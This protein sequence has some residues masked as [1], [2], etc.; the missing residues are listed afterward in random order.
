MSRG[1]LILALAGCLGLAAAGQQAPGRVLGIV[2]DASGQP[3]AGAMVRLS[4][5]G[6]H[7]QPVLRRTA[8]NGAFAYPRLSA[9]AYYIE[10]GRGQRVS[11]RHKIEVAPA[12]TA[13][14][15]LPL[16][17]VLSS[18]RV[19]AP[20]A[21]T[22]EDFGWLLRANDAVR[23]ILRWQETDPDAERISGFISVM[24]GG[25]AL[26]QADP[27]TVATAFEVQRS[28]W[29]DSAFTFGG[30]VG[31]A[32]LGVGGTPSQFSV[33]F[34]PH[35]DRSPARLVVSIQQ[36]PLP[37]VAR[38]PD[39]QA[40]S[41]NYADEMSVGHLTVQYGAMLDT[42]SMMDSMHALEP[43]LRVQ[44]QAGPHAHWE[45][46]FASAVPPV[47]FGPTYAQ[48]DA[49]LRLALDGFVASMERARHQEIGYDDDLTP[50]DRVEIAAFA[51]H[52]A[53]A[54]VAGNGAQAADLA[55]GNL[56][57]DSFNDTFSAD[58][59][60]YG[61][62][63]ARLE[64]QRRLTDTLR[65]TVAWA[66]SPILAPRPG[67]L[68]DGHFA[69]LLAEQRR[70]A[71]TFKVAGVVPVTHTR[72]AC[73]YRWL[74]GVSATPVDPYDDSSDQSD[75]FAN[76]TLRQ[77]LPHFAFG[78]NRVEALA[79]FHNLLAQGYIPVMSADGHLLYLIQA[80]R[81]FRGGLSFNF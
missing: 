80:A 54:V 78:G 50:N 4:P 37:P 45:Y 14:L 26:P 73:S 55:T 49:A 68:R 25:S 66:N 64:Y 43:Y 34:Q 58:G 65:A 5:V 59:G 81:S 1:F 56:L 39:V 31:S 15:A 23:P 3:M 33:A 62:L 48:A 35:G 7:R 17:Y 61:G 28:A 70:Q 60:N 21:R 63:G 75:S 47:H 76:I 18:L 24:A 52:F 32:P 77:P 20:G 8:L 41:F 46:R 36:I 53:H 72:V 38:A 9:G 12:R 71:V 74:N 16:L 2:T 11:G 40:V 22:E 79:E 69:S 19:G 57:P 13:Y 10:A 29:G 51:D 42:V 44:W 6:L 30:S 67:K 27:G